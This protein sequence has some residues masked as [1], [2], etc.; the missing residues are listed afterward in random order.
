MELT[1]QDIKILKHEKR[2]GFVFAGAILT[3]GLIFNII[4]I[5]TPNYEKDRLLLLLFID[6]PI[7]VLSYL[8]AFLMNRNINKD[9]RERIKIITTGKIERREHQIDYEPGSAMPAPGMREMKAYSKYILIL[10]GIEYDVEKEL[11]EDV[12]EG[13]TV[14]I[15]NSKYSDILLGVKK[16]NKNKYQY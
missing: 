7:I 1:K 13:D 3:F 4:F 10:K 8:T 16:R 2:L 15:H 9:L 11:F 6:L 5:A 14:E 12:K